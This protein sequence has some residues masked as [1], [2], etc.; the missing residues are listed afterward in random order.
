MEQW[1]VS[2]K[3]VFPLKHILCDRKNLRAV[4]FINPDLT[5]EIDVN[6]AGLQAD[7][8]KWLND[9]NNGPLILSGVQRVEFYEISLK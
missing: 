7:Y 3:Q 6:N 5:Y 2:P 4:F 9:E 8:K 1:G